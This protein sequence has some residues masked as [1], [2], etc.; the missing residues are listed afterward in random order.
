M[1]SSTFPTVTV[2][3]TTS[4]LS[5]R[6]NLFTLLGVIFL[7]LASTF[8][9]YALVHIGYIPTD[10]ALYTFGSK[11]YIHAW[12]RL[13]LHYG[14]LSRADP[15]SGPLQERQVRGILM[16]C[17]FFTE[18]ASST[19]TNVVV[20]LTKFAPETP[21]WNAPN[22]ILVVYTTATAL[23][24][25][26]LATNLVLKHAGLDILKWKEV[27]GMVFYGEKEQSN[28]AHEVKEEKHIV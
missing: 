7:T 22:S 9:P 20:L 4:E 12:V 14:R 13:A 27:A 18:L 25:D 5:S 8:R 11:L 24:F 19:I 15:G 23:A 28:A 6:Q 10:L 2:F 16:T 21:D 17:V 26:V 3:S 1:S